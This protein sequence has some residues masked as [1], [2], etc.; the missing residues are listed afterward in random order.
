VSALD[1]LVAV[2]TG[3]NSGIGRATA[4]LFAREGA[5]VVA[6]DRAP[7]VVDDRPD[8]AVDALVCDVRDADAV[9]AVGERVRQDHGRW[10]VLVNSAGV[11]VHGRAADTSEE[12]WDFV[13]SVNARGTWLMCRAALAAMVPAQ[14]GAI[15]NIASGAG[16]RPLEGLAAYAASKAA[17]VS[18]TRSIAVEY[19]GDGI[20]ANCICPGLV[21]T[22]IN[23]P[24]VGRLTAD[25]PE[26]APYPLARVGRADEIA[27]AALFLASPAASLVTGATLAVDAGRTLH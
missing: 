4:E 5:R 26:L 22:P 2:V 12:D 9:A 11:A 21:D 17:T 25:D 6:V 10:D 7:S 23:P 15:V 1:G 19:G 8:G 13:F 3:A 18:L 20:R 27:A 24:S 14:S 16:L